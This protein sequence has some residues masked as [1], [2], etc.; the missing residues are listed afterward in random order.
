[1]VLA[2]TG[3]K[4]TTYLPDV[5]TVIEGGIKGYDVSSWNGLSVPAGT[6]KTVV[7][8]LNA[9]MREVIPTPDVQ[10]KSTKMGM[11]MHWST[12]D[13]MTARMKSDIAKWGAVI[14]KAGIPKHD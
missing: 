7:A 9:A 14:A 5:P 13:D 8:T 4:R 2:S 11:E 1:V 6:P 12:P 10:S 3:E